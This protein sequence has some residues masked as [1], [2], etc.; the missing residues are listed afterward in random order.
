MK[1][2]TEIITTSEFRFN[3]GWIYQDSI[4]DTKE[5]DE[6]NPELIDWNEVAG[7]NAMPIEM[8]EEMHEINNRDVLWKIS[9]YKTKE[10][11]EM[12]EYAKPLDCLLKWQSEIEDEYLKMY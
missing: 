4:V 10:L 7:L 1:K 6:Y 5:I 12:E 9:I 8:I 2:Y 3:E 11:D